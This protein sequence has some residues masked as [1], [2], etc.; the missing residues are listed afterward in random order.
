M[1][2]LAS[3]QAGFPF[4]RRSIDFVGPLSA[5]SKGNKYILTVKDCFTRWIEA[6]PIVAA[7]ALETVDIQVKE[8]FGKY[9]VPEIIHSDR[10]NQFTSNL[11]H[12]VAQKY[13]I[14]V[15]T[16]QAYNPKSSPVKRVHRDLGTRLRA[17][18]YDAHQDW[19]AFSP[20][21]LF[22]IQKAV[23][24]SI[25]LAP[26]QLLFGRDASQPINIA[27]EIPREPPQGDL[28]C[29]RYAEQ[30]RNRIHN[31][32]TYT[33]E[34][35]ALVITR[36][37]RNYNQ[38]AKE[39]KVGEKVWL[40]TP[41]TKTGQGRKIAKFWSG[42]W[43]VTHKVNDICYNIVT[44]P[45]MESTAPPKTVPVDRLRLYRMPAAPAVLLFER[46]AG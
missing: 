18:S 44:A 22:A 46:K 6:F 15:T 21:A 7:T 11:F 14:Q 41:V 28:D 9:G 16:T 23:S 12:S 29:H 13:G 32:Q 5:S 33:R 37:R 8:I 19:K 30:L 31:A 20:Q 45:E 27:F 39:I 17:L 24:K 2:T 35:I 3:V 38:D 34:K 26:Y 10:G 4:Q 25:G 1:G 40:F 36:Q 43:I 42:P